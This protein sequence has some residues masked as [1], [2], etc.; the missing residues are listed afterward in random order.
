VID[1]HSHILPGLDDGAQTLD[2]A[3]AIARAAVAEGVTV[4]AA[5]PHVRS[6]YPTTAAQMRAALDDLRA[7]LGRE[8]IEL[9]VRPGGE[10]DYVELMRL[11]LD[12]LRPFALVGNPR[13]LLVETP[14]HGWPLGFADTVV[15]LA[16]NGIT[17]VIAHPERNADVQREPEHVAELVRSGALVQVTAASVDGRLGRSSRDCASRLLRE[18]LVHVLAS[19]AHTANVREVGLSRACAA[20]ADPPLARW[21]TVEAPGAIVADAELP[22]PPTRLRRR[23]LLSRLLGG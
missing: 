1:L 11:E 20:L 23:R 21:L 10:V 12:E 9:D 3:L 7:A 16:A 13:Y 8:G 6:D 5:T 22:P 14:Y 17:A 15:R 4:I 2:E 19:D 18:R